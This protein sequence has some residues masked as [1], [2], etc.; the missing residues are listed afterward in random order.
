MSAR[1]L[2]RRLTEDGVTFQEL[3][4]EARRELARHYLGQSS[5]ELNETAYLLGYKDAQL[6]L[7]RLP[8]V[9]GHV[10]RRV[11]E[12]ASRDDDRQLTGS[13]AAE[14]H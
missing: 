12:P 5:L 6:V 3:V 2:Q 7:P 10:A 13:L 11:A 8:P 4:E 14:P 9:G 1:T